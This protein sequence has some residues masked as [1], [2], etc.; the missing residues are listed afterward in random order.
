MVEKKGI[1]AKS[2]EFSVNLRRFPEIN[3]KCHYFWE[4][5]CFLWNFTEK[6]GN[7]KLNLIQT[8]LSAHWGKGMWLF[9]FFLRSHMSIAPGQSEASFNSLS[10][11]LK[12]LIFS[13]FFAPPHDVFNDLG[14]RWACDS[15]DSRPIVTLVKFWAV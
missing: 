10:N 11:I 13:N 6:N 2:T 14:A 12:L 4:S 3:W 5:P 9:L 1:S 8:S 15:I 7:R